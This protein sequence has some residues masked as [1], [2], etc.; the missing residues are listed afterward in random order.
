MNASTTKPIIDANA[1]EAMAKERP[2]EKF[3]KGSG[4]LKLIQA[5]RDLERAN[6]QLQAEQPTQIVNLR[7]AL[8]FYADGHHFI[9]SEADAWDTVS[10]EPQNY[11]CDEAGTATIEDGSIAMLALAGHPIKFEDNDAQSRATAKAA[12]AAPFNTETR[13]QIAA[14]ML[15]HGTEDQQRAALAYASGAPAAPSQQESTRTPQDFAIEHAEYMAA[16]AERLIEAVNADA[17]VRLRI[18]ESDDVP[19]DTEH[20]AQ[21]TVDEMLRS[22]RERIHE[23]RKRRDRA[24]RAPVAAQADSQPAQCPYSID[25]DPQGI[26]S[27]V[28]EAITGALAFG[29]QGKNPPPSG[30]WLAPFWNAARADRPQTDSVLTFQQ[31]VQPWLLECFGAEIAAD[32]IER[33]HRFLEESLELVQAL[34]CTAS[35]AHQLV[36]YVFG[37]PVG[38]P[39]QEVGGVM[40][41]LAALCL[42][43]GLDMHDAGEVEL[44]RISAPELVARIRAKQAAKPKHSPLPQSPSP[45]ADSQPAPPTEYPALPE[46]SATGLGDEYEAFDREGR[47]MGKAYKT[48]LYFKPDQMRAY[49]DADRAA[50]K[51]GGV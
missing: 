22:V 7:K 41:T 25:A 13:D 34:G 20:D 11:W 32:R 27:R 9:K 26:R 47:A 51:Q 37:R 30:H 8:Q 36:D 17:A 21:A 10:G 3:L 16:S 39:P 31:R 1:L 24:A 28:A 48:I 4:V 6:R 18:A 42:A 15:Q 33:N 12:P 50:R 23:F 19:D 35:E 29:A 45:H 44:A 49:V 46:P 14:V 2:N 40:V 5:I 38:D 43:S